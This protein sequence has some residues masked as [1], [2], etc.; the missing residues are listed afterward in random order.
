M[1][2]NGTTPSVLA[3]RSICV[4]GALA[5]LYEAIEP[6]HGQEPGP[7]REA[8]ESMPLG[9]PAAFASAER[10]TVEIPPGTPLRRAPT[11]SSTVAFEFPWDSAEQAVVLDRRDTASGTWLRVQFGSI[12]GWYRESAKDL[13]QIAALYE[14]PAR[15][16]RRERLAQLAGAHFDGPPS[17]VTWT[18]SGESS[19]QIPV[20]LFTDLGRPPRRLLQELTSCVP[21]LYAARFGAVA[22]SRRLPVDVFL[23]SDQTEYERF[24]SAELAT[25]IQESGGLEIDGLVFVN[26]ESTMLNILGTVAHELAHVLNRFAFPENALPVWI[27]EGIAEDIAHAVEAA[28]V[29]GKPTCARPGGWART[30]VRES[31]EFVD[32]KPTRRTDLQRTGRG[33][34]LLCY[35]GPGAED[36]DVRDLTALEFGVSYRREVLYLEAVLLLRD[37]TSGV[38]TD[39]A[40]QLLLD[41]R[42]EADSRTMEAVVARSLTPLVW[43]TTERSW[44]RCP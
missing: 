9:A 21:A 19:S 23:F 38:E 41:W 3:L 32:G 4:F 20:R 27:E 35:E 37:L 39:Q 1:T 22:P 26:G 5:F 40:Q 13:D 6:L 30:Q 7:V 17:L 14:N 34:V 16:E 8:E 42:R 29:A 44:M 24:A 12:Y 15:L 25:S 31:T 18:L 11:L 43:R 2:R 33:R 10:D 28:V 36:P